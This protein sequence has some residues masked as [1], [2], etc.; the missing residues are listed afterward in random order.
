LEAVRQWFYPGQEPH[1]APQG[2]HYALELHS[3]IEAQTRIGWRQLFNGRFC[4]HWADI[5]T[6]HLYNIR[7]QLP[8][9]NNSG[10]K[11]QIAIITV[12]WEAWYD[13]WIMRNADVHGEDEATRAVAA[14]R[15]VTRKLALIYDQRQ[16]MEPSTQALLFPDIRTHLEPLSWVI[17]TWLTI[18]GPTFMQSLRNVKAKALQNVRSIREY[19]APAPR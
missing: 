16:H 9:K 7:N 13:L 19:Y 3:L 8:T 5:Q 1:P 11:W 15:E 4:R 12:I 18:K 17:Q 2:E 10:H 6:V 14:K